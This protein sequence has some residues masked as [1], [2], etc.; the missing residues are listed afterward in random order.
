MTME[1]NPTNPQGPQELELFLYRVS[2]DLR[3]PVLVIQGFIGE[4]KHSIAENNAL[5]TQENLEH[6]GQAAQKLNDMLEALLR[7]SRLNTTQMPHIPLDLVPMLLGIAQDFGASFELPKNASIKG[8]AEHLNM[9][10]KIIVDN[11]QKYSQ[12]P[13]QMDLHIEMQRKGDFWEIRWID[14]GIGIAP[15]MLEKCLDI[16]TR[17]NAKSPGTG[18]GLAIAKRIVE[19]HQGTLHLESAGNEQGTTVVVR[20][21]S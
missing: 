13:P 17:V 8:Q 18:A 9:L 20:L 5:E 4:L 12:N 6:L 19:M 21:P 14:Q 10:F 11:A 7:L 1:Q 16:F 3:S 2:H 15:S